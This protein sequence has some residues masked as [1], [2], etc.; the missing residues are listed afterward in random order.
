MKRALS[1]MLLLLGLLLL[2]WGYDLHRQLDTQVIRQVLGRFPEQVWHYYL[3]GSLALILG[4]YGLIR[5]RG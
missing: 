1:I 4:I 5:F 2:Y 3:T